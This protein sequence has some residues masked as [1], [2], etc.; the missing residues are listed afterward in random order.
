M[1]ADIASAVK[2]QG[3]IHI[4]TGEGKGKTTSAIGLAARA[5][6]RNLKVKIIQLFKRDT[7]EYFILKSKINYVQ[8]KPLHPFFK[9]YSGDGLKELKNEFMKF[10]KAETKDI[11]KYDVLIIDELSSALN[12]KIIDEKTIIDFINKKPKKLELI[13][14][15][16][17]FPKSILKKADY[18]SDIQSVKHPFEKGI[19][20]RKGI[21]Y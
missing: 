4:Y 10:W 9:K 8:F 21:E 12:W 13:F 3:L 15:G 18:I 14:T 6:G 17:N 20:A 7:G 16:R 5:L 1:I 2:M 19:K 11:K